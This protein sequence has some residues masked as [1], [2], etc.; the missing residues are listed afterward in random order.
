MTLK[1]LDHVGLRVSDKARA[2]AFFAAL[3]F[4]PEPGE[5]APEHKAI[6][7]ITASGVRL[8]LIYNARPF[9]QGNVLL[10]IDEKW[11]GW[12]HA[13]F[14]V[15]DLDA[16]IADLARRGVPL[17]GGP[18]VYGDGRRRVCFIRDPDRNVIEF[19]EILEPR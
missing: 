2:L 4:E 10:D 12:T 11:P 6:G 17:S 9:A 3:G 18:D 13:A 14:I 1:A 15:D 19:N 5:D 16:V 8:N 7:L